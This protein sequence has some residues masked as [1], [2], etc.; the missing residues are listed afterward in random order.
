MAPKV[1]E[2]PTEVKGCLGISTIILFFVALGLT[3]YLS[4]STDVILA[5]KELSG[6][7]LIAIAIAWIIFGFFGLQMIGVY[8][9]NSP[10]PR[11]RLGTG[12]A[13]FFMFT[14]GVSY[15]VSGALNPIVTFQVASTFEVIVLVVLCVLLFFL[16]IH[17][18]FLLLLIWKIE[19]DTGRAFDDVY[20]KFCDEKLIGDSKILKPVLQCPNCSKWMH[21]ICWKKNGGSIYDEY[22]PQCEKKDNPSNIMEDFMDKYKRI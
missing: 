14:L 11:V 1:N 19:N 5:F 18:L 7:Q 12:I 2:L 15:V 17:F 9:G 13:I 4:G 3:Y 6:I 8:W 22:C 16:I 21:M 10:D 20:C